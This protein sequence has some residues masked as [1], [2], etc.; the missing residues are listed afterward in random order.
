MNKSNNNNDNGQPR[1]Q[2]SNVSPPNMPNIPMAHQ[3]QLQNPF[4]NN[5]LR[6][7][8]Y[9]YGPNINQMNNMLPS[10]SIPQLQFPPNAQIDFQALLAHSAQLLSFENG[11]AL[12]NMVNENNESH[13]HQSKMMHRHENRAHNQNNN[14]ARD[15]GGRNDRR[16]DQSRSP[17]RDKNEWIRN[18]GRDHRSDRRD[19]SDR[20]N[21]NNRNDNNRRR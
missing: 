10:A 7:A 11:I 13:K 14:Y 12:N 18:K 6:G 19:R 1:G 21:R 5:A 20:H 17:S 3:L 8:N 9:N 16:N 15:R 2:S 4:G